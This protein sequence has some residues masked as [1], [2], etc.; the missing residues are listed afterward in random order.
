MLAAPVLLF[1]LRF[2]CIWSQCD[3]NPVNPSILQRIAL[4]KFWFDFFFL[5]VL[6]WF[7][8]LFFFV[9]FY[10]VFILF[11]I[12]SLSHEVGWCYVCIVYDY[13]QLAT[14]NICFCAVISVFTL[15]V[16]GAWN[17]LV[18]PC[19]SHYFT[20]MHITI[21]SKLRWL[22]SFLLWQFCFEH[23]F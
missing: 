10:F 15:L 13:Q 20:L 6:I 17:L 14:L 9:C 5:F 4:N 8:F 21:H 18:K 16:F 12:G 3:I 23:A 22:S 7:F 11:W 2:T 19:H 1:L